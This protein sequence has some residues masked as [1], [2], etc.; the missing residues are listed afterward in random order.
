LALARIQAVFVTDVWLRLSCEITSRQPLV[1]MLEDD[2]E[3]S[4]S[5]AM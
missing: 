4:S 1:L 5:N 3:K 2:F